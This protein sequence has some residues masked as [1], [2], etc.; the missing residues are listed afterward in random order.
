MTDPAIPTPDAPRWLHRWTVLT[1]CATLGLLVLGSLVTTLRA[2]MAD[3]SGL[4]QPLHLL[5]ADLVAEAERQ[6]Y[7]VHLYVLEHS[8]RAA[9]WLIGL[10]SIVLCAWLWIADR[11]A[12]MKWLGTLALVGV[13]LQGVLGGLRVHFHVSYGI[14]LATI[15]GCFAQLVFALLVG[16]ALWTSAWWNSPSSLARSPRLRKMTLGV[17]ALVYV[18]VIFGAI[19]RHSHPRL[20]QRLHFLLAFAVFGAILWLL[21]ALREEANWD[22]RVRWL[23]RV[24]MAVLTFQVMLGV[25]AW[26]MRFGNYMLPEQLPFSLGSAIVRTLHFVFGTLLFST[27]VALALLARRTETPASVSAPR[28]EGVLE[29]VA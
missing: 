11:R 8:H 16:L 19:V 14:D 29:G 15:H 5:Q 4:R 13:S 25:E 1:V 28:R 22:R 20:A 6:G 7:A 17:C 21:M 12:W 24:L 10:M 23:G 18:Q 26:M 3:K 27:T 9:G 2:G